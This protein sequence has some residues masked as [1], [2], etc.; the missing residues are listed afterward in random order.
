MTSEV[1]VR[2]EWKKDRGKEKRKEWRLIASQL[3]CKEQKKLK[4]WNREN[5]NLRSH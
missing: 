1:L 3:T 2:K 4:S 5:S